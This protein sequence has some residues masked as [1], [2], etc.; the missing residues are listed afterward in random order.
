MWGV[1]WPERNLGRVMKYTACEKRSVVRTTVLPA[2]GGSQVAK[3]SAIWDQW[4]FQVWCSRPTGRVGEVLFWRQVADSHSDVS[5]TF[6]CLRIH[7]MGKCCY[8]VV[9]IWQHCS[10]LNFGW[11]TGEFWHAWPMYILRL[12]NWSNIKDIEKPRQRWRCFQVVSSGQSRT[13]WTLA[14][15]AL[16]WLF[17][18]L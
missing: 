7:I 8:N 14:G 3:S 16:I 4:H 6:V 2:D 17:S 10:N 11:M 13:A 15:L 12:D 5:E 1:S 18:E 9:C